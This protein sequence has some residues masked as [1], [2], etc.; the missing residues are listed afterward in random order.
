MKVLVSA[1]LAGINCRHDGGHKVNRKIKKMVE[2]GKAVCVCPEQLGGLDTPRKPAEIRNASGKDVL[3]GRAK[4]IREDGKDLTDCFI[5]GARQ[6]LAIAKKYNIR[7]AIL[8]S[9]S[10]A[11]GKGE[12]YDGSFL[13][14]LTKANGVTCQLLLDNNIKV[15]TEKDV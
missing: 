3:E 2:D 4:V 8:K 6:T 5:K 1:C 12:I 15:I 14:K 13:N 9:K 10:A 11:C 7:K